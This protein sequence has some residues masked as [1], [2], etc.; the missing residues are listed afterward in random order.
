MLRVPPVAPASEQTSLGNLMRQEPERAQQLFE[1][2]V[3]AGFPAVGRYAGELLRI[4][5]TSAWVRMPPDLVLTS[6][7]RAGILYPTCAVDRL[8]AGSIDAC[9]RTRTVP[10]RGG[11]W[12][13]FENTSH[14]TSR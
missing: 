11:P 9:S 12:P 14:A 6:T 13:D 5:E 7:D 10:D 4:S 1:A 8:A 3:L 2:V